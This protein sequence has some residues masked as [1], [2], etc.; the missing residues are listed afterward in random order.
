MLKIEVSY[1]P[2]RWLPIVRKMTTN[3]PQNWGDVSKLQLIAIS[4]LYKS[5][6]SDLSFLKAMTGLKKRILQSLSDF[7]RY[8]LMEIFGFIGDPKPYHQFIIRK[9]PSTRLYAPQAKLKGVTFA[10]FI[11]ADTY[12]A[13]YQQSGDQADLNKFIASLYL[14]KNE[15]FDERLIAERFESIGKLNENI[16]Q[17]IVLN[18][19]LIHEWLMLAYPLIFQKQKELLNETTGHAESALAPLPDSNTWIKVFQN[20]VGDDIIHDEIWAAKPINTILAY[21]TRKYK[22]NARRK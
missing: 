17:S 16:R 14:G 13:S 6:I 19:Q 1:R 18:Y 10:Q 15:S 11:F 4:S 7:E 22:E 3:V 12:F 9:L 21:M 8:K 20:F 5:A 2:I